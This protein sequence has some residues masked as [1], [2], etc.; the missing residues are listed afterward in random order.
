M[1]GTSFYLVKPADKTITVAWYLLLQCFFSQV[2]SARIPFSPHQQFLLF[3][4]SSTGLRLQV[5]CSPRRAQLLLLLYSWYQTGWRDCSASPHPFHQIHKF[6][7]GEV[8]W[9]PNWAS[10][11][12]LSQSESF[13]FPTGTHNELTW[14]LLLPFVW[15]KLV[16]ALV[17][18][19]VE[20][21]E[22]WQITVILKV[23]VLWFGRRY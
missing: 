2:L 10:C 21:P 19:C 20:T 22:K 12:C 13:P 5:P 6:N 1:E 18:S 16:L 11:R 15:K 7:S 14:I 3:F 4:P 17:L 9:L 23:H 8:N